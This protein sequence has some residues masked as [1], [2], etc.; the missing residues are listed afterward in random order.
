MSMLTV[1]VIPM[2]SRLVFLLI[3]ANGLYIW[4]RRL[5]N[6]IVTSLAESILF[7]IYLLF[8]IGIIVW[9]TVGLVTDIN[10]SLATVRQQEE[11][12]DERVE[13]DARYWHQHQNTNQ[14]DVTEV[15]E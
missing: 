13:T 7:F 10:S 2:I 4:A 6:N 3:V 9:S 5:E 8:S 1:I 14:Q 11:S 15:H 12:M